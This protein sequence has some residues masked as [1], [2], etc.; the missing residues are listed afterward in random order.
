ML[1]AS[2][3]FVFRRVGVDAQTVL[4]PVFTSALLAVS[5]IASATPWRLPADPAP[6]A[7]TR[8]THYWTSNETR[9]DLF[10]DAVEQRGGVYVGVGTDQNYVLAGWAQP[11][12]MVLMDFDEAIVGLHSAYAV[13]FTRS[14]TPE[15]F[16][17]WW[18][19]KK[20]NAFRRAIKSHFK[21]EPKKRRAALK[22]H[23]TARYV[24]EKRLH[25]LMETFVKRKATFLTDP[26]QYAFVRNLVLNDRV[27]AVRGDLTQDRTVRAI[28]RLAKADAATVGV[29]YMSNAEQ[30]FPYAWRFRRNIKALPFDERSVVVRTSGL[31]SLPRV[32]GT[33]YHYNTQAGLSFQQFLSQKRARNALALLRYGTPQAERGHSHIMGSPEEAKAAR[34]AARAAARGKLNVRPEEAP[35]I[36][37][38][39]AEDGAANRETAKPPVEQDADARP[40]PAT[41]P[42]DMA[43]IP[44]GPFL[45]GSNNKRH[46][47]SRPQ[48]TVYV[49]T[50]LMDKNEVTY[51]QYKACER[52]GDC[53][54]AGPNYRDFDAPRQ[55]I[56]GVSWYAAN[57]YC[58][59]NGKHL[60][61]EAEW[62][63]AARGTDGRLYP[64]G[65]QRATCERAIIKDKRGRSCG[66]KQKSR[67]FADVGRPE[68]VGQRP[69]NDYGLYDMAGNSWEWVADWY[70]ASYSACGSACRGR[71]PRGACA[72]K[73]R[74]AGNLKVV[75]GGSWYWPAQYATTVYRRPHHPWNRP[76]HHF[77]FRCAKHL[78]GSGDAAK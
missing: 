70:T 40:C 68:P 76:F 14:D 26:A 5:A 57:Q 9:L 16:V 3:I 35:V 24:V 21:A 7:I 15:Q 66:K 2:Q 12:R 4:I 64:W 74:C 36:A 23:Y 50:F 1:R 13:A 43:C 58:I 56:N 6:E 29:F 52:R 55:P 65:N 34:K 25:W 78:D 49:D 60:P 38:S 47:R 39:S 59:A 73:K 46:K 71:N 51:S 22:A 63:K 75:R 8:D 10:F 77:G 18:T 20:R 48:A 69:P 28:G 33:Y 27:A 45:R 41:L 44:G 17:T 61:T 53:K 19:K 72:G 31:K 30:Y 42:D 37:A 32:R 54:K 11:E 67:K 62:E